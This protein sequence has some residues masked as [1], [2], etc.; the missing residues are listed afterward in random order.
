VLYDEADFDRILSALI[1]RIES[2][3]VANR[4]AA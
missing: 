3:R 2:A 4:S 1:D